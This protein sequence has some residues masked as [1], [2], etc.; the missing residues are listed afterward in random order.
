[1][2]TKLVEPGSIR[3]PAFVERH[4]LGDPDHRTGRSGGKQECKAAGR[5]AFPLPRGG[6]FVEDAALKSTA[7]RSID[8]RDPEPHQGPALAHASGHQRLAKPGHDRRSIR[9]CRR[10]G[11]PRLEA[12]T[13]RQRLPAIRREPA[14]WNCVPYLFY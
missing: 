13:H 8:G 1:M 10:E 2:Q 12:C 4:V 14:G 6:N 9:P 11:C 5:G 7:K 3:H